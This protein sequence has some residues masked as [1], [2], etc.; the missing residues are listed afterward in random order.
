M[1]TM[2]EPTFS[3]LQIA[4]M[5]NRSPQW[6]HLVAKRLDIGHLEGKALRFTGAQLARIAQEADPNET[7]GRKP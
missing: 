4:E 5:V 3:T 2:L 7:R 6:V 1:P